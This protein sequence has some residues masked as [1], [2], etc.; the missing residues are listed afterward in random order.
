MRNLEYRWA[1]L[2]RVLL[3]LRFQVVLEVTKQT[4]KTQRIALNA[5]WA[6]GEPHIERLGLLGDRDLEP[7]IA[8]LSALTG[9]AGAAEPL[10]I[11]T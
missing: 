5:G 6:F 2:F 7:T 9:P 10:A 11:V 8:N 3:Q 1:V 4:W